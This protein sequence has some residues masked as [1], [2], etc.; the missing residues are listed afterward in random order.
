MFFTTRTASLYQFFYFHIFLMSQLLRNDS[1]TAQP[2]IVIWESLCPKHCN[3]HNLL[4]DQ[5]SPILLCISF[6]NIL[7]DNVKQF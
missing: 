5:T 1:L 2:L 4:R 7:T 6:L 3:R